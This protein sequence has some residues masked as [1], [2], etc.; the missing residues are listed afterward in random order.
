[1]KGACL[2]QTTE[3][4]VF[5][6]VFLFLEHPFELLVVKRKQVSLL[7]ATMTANGKLVGTLVDKSS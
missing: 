5:V 2:P 3:V 7:L 6:V 4:T 1:M